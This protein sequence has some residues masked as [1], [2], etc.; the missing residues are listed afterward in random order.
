[1]GKSI[2]WSCSQRGA[3]DLKGNSLQ[4]KISSL[5]WI[6]EGSF[7]AKMWE[8]KIILCI[9]IIQDLFSV[10]CGYA[11]ANCL[12]L[13]I[14]IFPK[15][16]LWFVWPNPINQTR[17][18]VKRVDFSFQ[19]HIKWKIEKVKNNRGIILRKSTCQQYMDGKS[20]KPPFI[21]SKCAN[22]CIWSVKQNPNS[23]SQ[24]QQVQTQNLKPFYR[25]RLTVFS[26]SS[27]QRSA[28]API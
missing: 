23:S 16:E 9:Q 11:L 18:E 19:V 22:L 5:L 20:T 10:P 27:R 4:S 26:L 6:H 21:V 12:S 28:S 2:C 24:L 14:V 13:L 3:K 15:I 1:M 8:L 25:S 7:R 17:L